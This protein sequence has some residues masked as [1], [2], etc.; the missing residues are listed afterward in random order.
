MPPGYACDLVLLSCKAFD[1]DSAIAAIAP[2]VGQGTRVLPLLNG[3]KH[4]DLL[5]LAFGRERV[6]GG[7]AHISVTL[8][9]AG[10]VIH[11]TNSPLK[12]EL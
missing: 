1:L 2:A 12:F 9:D 7:L 5:D 10:T 11:M 8:D 3:L 4:L 6:W